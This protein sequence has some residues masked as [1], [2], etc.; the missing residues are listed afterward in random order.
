MSLD[1]VA[2]LVI[3]CEVEQLQREIWP[4]T[5]N[6]CW[7][8]LAYVD[9]MR[10]ETQHMSSIHV[11]QLVNKTYKQKKWQMHVDGSETE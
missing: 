6:S 11:L 2:F 8:E 1:A 9:N 3:I 5:V 4:D 10:L 7:I